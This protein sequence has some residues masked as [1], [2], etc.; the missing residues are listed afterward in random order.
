MFPP[1]TDDNVSNIALNNVQSC[2]FAPAFISNFIYGYAIDKH[3]KIMH[4]ITFALGGGIIAFTMTFFVGNPYDWKLYVACMILGATL[5][6]IYILA[7]FL[8]SR[9]YSANKRGIMFG[10]QTLIGYIG[11]VIIASGGGFLFDHWTHNAPFVLYTILLSVA[12]I[13]IF[14]IYFLKIKKSANAQV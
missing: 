13:L 1:E 2:I 14:L 10:I 6:G 8:G 9:Y 7:N 5:T 3:N 11:Y 12:L 4:S